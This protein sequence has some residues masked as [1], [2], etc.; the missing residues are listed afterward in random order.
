MSGERSVR[1]WLSG[2]KT[3][4]LW[5]KMRPPSMV[6]GVRGGWPEERHPAGA[7]K[8]QVE[9]FDVGGGEHFG[10]QR[11]VV[12]GLKLEPRMDTN[13]ECW[14]LEDGRGRRKG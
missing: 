8:V 3:T 10:G 9:R 7:G 13:W 11:S 12:K 6:T 2:E 5:E 1:M 4:P 14:R